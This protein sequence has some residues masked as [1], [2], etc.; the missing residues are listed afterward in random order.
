MVRTQAIPAQHVH[1]FTSLPSSLQVKTVS[2][3][4]KA[5]GAL[6]KL[7]EANTK[8]LAEKAKSSE[9]NE[10]LSERVSALQVMHAA[11][12]AARAHGLVCA[13]GVCVCGVWCVCVCVC[14]CVCGV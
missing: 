3:L 9:H 13:C 11:T 8:L 6:V 14:M 2:L 7:T 1:A 10:A 5:M 4:D 12:A